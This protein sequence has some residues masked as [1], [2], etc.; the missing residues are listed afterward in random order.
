M[1]CEVVHEIAEIDQQTEQ[2]MVISTRIVDQHCAQEV[3]TSLTAKTCTVS[4]SSGLTGVK[5]R[6][7][8]K[9]AERH[10]SKQL[11]AD[12]S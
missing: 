7:E 11:S 1:S 5:R 3:E 6:R 4:Q 10:E 9:F 2:S 8:S 12:T